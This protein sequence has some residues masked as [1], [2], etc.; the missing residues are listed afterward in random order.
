MRA[1]RRAHSVPISNGSGHGW[2]YASAPTGA[3][4]AGRAAGEWAALRRA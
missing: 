1:A 4:L 3:L 2:R